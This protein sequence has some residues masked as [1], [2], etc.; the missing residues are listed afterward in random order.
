MAPE[1][2]VLEESFRGEVPGG[3]AV[4]P[5]GPL[6]EWGAFK[7]SV[8]PVG[9]AD[10]GKTTSRGRE[11]VKGWFDLRMRAVPGVAVVHLFGEAVD[12]G[13]ISVSASRP[14]QHTSARRPNGSRA[15]VML[16]TSRTCY[17]NA[18]ET[19][20]IRCGVN[21]SDISKVALGEGCEDAHGLSKSPDG[22]HYGGKGGILQVGQSS[23]IAIKW[24]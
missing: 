22:D 3:A 4:A 19:I 5:A 11:E 14:P 7:R 16:K 13:A 20:C 2:H 15:R 8:V 23:L 9:A 18:R 6:R 24:R 1:A 12:R 21:N 17:K 10:L